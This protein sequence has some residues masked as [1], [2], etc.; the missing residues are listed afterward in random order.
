MFQANHKIKPAT[1]MNCGIYGHHFRNCMAPITSY[2]MIIFRVKGGWNQSKE[3]VQNMSSISGLEHSVQN[4]QYL[5]IQRKDS[6]GFVDIMRGKYKVE[7]VD[8]IMNQLNGLTAVEKEKLLTVP[9]DTLWKD[10]W[11]ID[12]DAPSHSYRN[13]KEVAKAKLEILRTGLKH[14]ETGEE[15]KLEDLM[16]KVKTSWVTP[17]W[18]FPK[19]RRDHNESE[20]TCALREVFE[21]TGLTDKDICFIRNLL[22]I[23][24]TFFGTN[25]LHYCHKYYL[26]YMEKE[27]DI[28]ID[29][30]NKM[31]VREI[32]NIG[33]FSLEEALE[34]IRPD[35]VE[36]KEILLKAS[37]L[38]RNYCPLIVS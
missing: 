25:R 6:L 21:E 12:P 34:R 3:L 36:K 18:G 31:M 37:S 23:Q 11:G 30:T 17:E 16:A 7:D 29:P 10:L 13:E 19:G 32:G 2:G 22:P 28:S 27:K 35:N 20:F 9:F 8:Y 5:L 26:S 24:E 38:L 33:W 14:P 1:C 4:I 15:I